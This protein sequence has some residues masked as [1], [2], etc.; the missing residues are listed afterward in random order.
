MVEWRDCY[1]R[2]TIMSPTRTDERV[3]CNSI[4]SRKRRPIGVPDQVTTVYNLHVI[5]EKLIH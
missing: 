2:V 1:E 4:M 3:N 5:Y